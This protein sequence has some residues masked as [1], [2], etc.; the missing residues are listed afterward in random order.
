MNSEPVLMPFQD[1]P[2]NG[3]TTITKEFLVLKKKFDIK[4]AI[5]TGTCLGYTTLWLAHNFD[6]VKS[7]EYNA[8][9][10]EIA[11]NRIK[12]MCNVELVHGKSQLNL[13]SLLGDGE[14]TIFFLDA[15]WG[16]E[17]PL[18]EE[19]DIIAWSTHCSPTEPIIAIHDFKVP[20]NPELGYDAYEGKPFT[21]EGVK[22]KFDA[23][24]GK[25]GYDHY[26]NSELEGAQRGI[27]YVVPKK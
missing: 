13:P 22:P 15:H 1:Q 16:S 5:E 27:I 23:I 4:V 12:D 11:Q 10:F 9:Y 20:D 8:D 25:K 18:E 6:K 21:V 7:V 17:C 24:Y 19:L 3:D 26:Y 14:R 2:F